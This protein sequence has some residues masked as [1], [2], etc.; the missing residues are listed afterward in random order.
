MIRSRRQP[1]TR[2]LIA[3][4]AAD[5]PDIVATLDALP[6]TAYGQVFVEAVHPDD[7]RPLAAPG[8]VTVTWL[9][10]STRSSGIGEL[11]FADHGEAVARALVGWAGE[12][13]VDDQDPEPTVVW[14]GCAASPWIEQARV[15]L[16]E[17]DTPAPSGLL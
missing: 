15:V 8:R 3:G 12:W 9:L 6:D 11:V 2:V 7:V 17:L 4:D 16:S 1:R 13:L 5:L 14:L 10:R